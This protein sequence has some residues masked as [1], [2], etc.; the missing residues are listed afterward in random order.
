M[1]G[2]FA[3]LSA[4]ASPGAEFAVARDAPANDFSSLLEWKNQIAADIEHNKRYLPGVRTRGKIGVVY[5]DLNIN[6]SGWVLPGTRI[7]TVDREIGSA[8]LLLLQQSQPFPAPDHVGLRDAAFRILVPIR[9]YEIP[10]QQAAGL[11]DLERR[12]LLECYQADREELEYQ[13]RKAAYRKAEPPTD[14]H[15]VPE[16]CFEAKRQDAERERQDAER[17]RQQADAL[18]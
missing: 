16:G 3:V 2:I 13:R 5:F 6:R 8:A 10:P 7:V 4:L 1:L 9:F 11:A 12:K 14:V 15:R 18:R 17:R